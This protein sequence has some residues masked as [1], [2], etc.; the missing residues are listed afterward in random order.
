MR[1]VSRSPAVIDSALV[2]LQVGRITRDGT[3]TYKPFV[4]IHDAIFTII[5]GIEEHGLAYGR[6]TL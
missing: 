6:S 3:S 2:G 4:D 5:P 1:V